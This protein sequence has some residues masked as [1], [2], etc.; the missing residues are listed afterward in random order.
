MYFWQH[1][2]NVT[3]AVN[4]IA[5][6]SIAMGFLKHFILILLG[7]NQIHKMKDIPGIGPYFEEKILVY[8][9]I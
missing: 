9:H 6:F 8:R 3:K 1:F 7:R 4:N 2:N 5:G